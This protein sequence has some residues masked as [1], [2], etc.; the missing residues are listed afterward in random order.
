MFENLRRDAA[1]YEELGSWY[2]NAGFWIVAIY[3]MG[4]WAHTLPFYLRIPVWV[5]YRLVRPVPYRLFNVILWA[6]PRGAR[7][8][9]GFCLIHPTDIAIGHG[10]EIGED[11]LV[12]H[13]VT[14][15][16]GPLP[17]YPK[18][19][20]GVDIYV[21]AR[22]LGGISI[23]DRSMVGANCV[24]TK[25]I[26]ADSV[27]LPVPSRVIPRKLSPVARATD[28]QA[29]PSADPVPGAGEGAP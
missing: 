5:L 21:G 15:A 6:G 20:R 25:S 14:L 23:G 4:V 19:G 9:A 1:K 7:V 11:C 28:Q 26:P 22:V 10:V 16:T 27:V 24:V 13:D 12:F 8:G 17:G 29:R 3:R 2:R 18:I